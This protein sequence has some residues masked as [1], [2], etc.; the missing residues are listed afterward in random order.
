MFTLYSWRRKRDLCLRYPNSLRVVNV[1]VLF[2]RNVQKCCT[3]FC[4]PKKAESIHQQREWRSN[5]YTHYRPD[6]GHHSGREVNISNC[7]KPLSLLIR[8]SSFVC[9]AFLF[10]LFLLFLLLPSVSSR[11]LI[12]KPSKAGLKVKG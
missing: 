11:P 4:K 10:I 5:P 9:V 1:Y 3:F 2:Q 8:F 6:A 7:P 12:I